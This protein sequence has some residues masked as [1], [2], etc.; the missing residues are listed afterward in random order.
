MRA[1]IVGGSAVKVDRHFEYS[2]RDLAY[3]V[4]SS[5]EACGNAEYIVVASALPE[6]M[7]HQVDL[8]VHIVQWAGRRVPVVRV[9]SGESSGIAAVEVATSLI[10]SGT[11]RKVVVLG[12][13]KVT[14]YPTYIANRMYSLILDYEFEVLR[15]VS[16][17]VYAAL[18][19]RE[20]LKVGFSR[21]CFSSWAVKMHENATR[22]PHAM[23]KF[24][25]S[26][27]S[28]KEAQVL[29]EPVTLYD[30]FALGD[31]ASAIALSSEPVG[32]EVAVEV[33]YGSSEVG[34]P[35]YARD[36]VSELQA[37]TKLLKQLRERFGVDLRKVTVELHDSYTPY[38]IAL[39]YSLGYIDTRC[40]LSEL[41]FI[42]LSGGLKARG[43]PIGATGVY[44]VYE[45]FKLLTG[46]FDGVSV[47][48]E[49]GVVHSMSGPDNAS[50]VL[51]LRRW[52]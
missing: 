15:G 36:R 35:A 22:I 48:S 42:N 18:A 19:M 17:P 11:A 30:S 43:H 8:G 9:E 16:P 34:L 28:F 49:V 23:L 1:Y 41:E 5:C 10:H 7:A 39:L 26:P 12:V 24:K 6:L 38:P 50:R 40:E 52:R 3:N 21:E 45:V 31:G 46:G 14:E 44:Q 13:E 33:V 27:E 47:S 20:L 32:Y 51:L 2:Y 25:I 4:L 29:A 37:S